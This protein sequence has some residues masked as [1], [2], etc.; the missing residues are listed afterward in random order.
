MRYGMHQHS[1][2]LDI[3]K[4]RALY[5]SFTGHDA[6]LLKRIKKPTFP[7]VGVAI[8]RVLGIIYE[9]RRDGRLETYRHNF[10]KTSRPLFVVSPDGKQLM[11]L[12]G[13]YDFTERGIVDRKRVKRRR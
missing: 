13:A 4:G 2:K 10:G 9:T 3:E 7:S 1:V 5:Q 11:M 6:K 8:G 12:G